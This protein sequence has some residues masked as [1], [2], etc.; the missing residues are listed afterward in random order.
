MFDFL[1]ALPIFDKVASWFIGE[2]S[3][4]RTMGLAYMLITSA[5]Y[6]LIDYMNVDLYKNLMGFGVLWTG[7][8]FS[9]KISKLA[10]AVQDI[11]ETK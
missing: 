6:L 7:S 5:V 11:K 1:K 10:K 3:H 8:A 2:N 9:A 4:K